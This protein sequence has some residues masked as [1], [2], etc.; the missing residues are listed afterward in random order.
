MRVRIGVTD[1]LANY[2]TWEENRKTFAKVGKI[3]P[4]PDYQRQSQGLVHPI[5]DIALV[6]LDKVSGE[7]EVRRLQIN[8]PFTCL[9][10]YLCLPTLL[11]PGE[12]D[13]NDLQVIAGWGKTKTDKR[14]R[15]LQYGETLSPQ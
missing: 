11:P 7:K 3:I 14:P 1:L 10:Q 8:F 5:N 9:A 2:S 6:K 4:H 13:A 12:V 15:H